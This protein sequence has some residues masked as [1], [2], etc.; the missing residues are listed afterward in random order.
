L[1][2]LSFGQDQD[3]VS[4]HSRANHRIAKLDSFHYW[5]II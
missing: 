1:F 2:F 5:G 4:S 3:R